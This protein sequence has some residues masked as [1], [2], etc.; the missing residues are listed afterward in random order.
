VNKNRT[1]KIT[2]DLA[3]NST[4]KA[5]NNIIDKRFSS[6]SEFIPFAKEEMKKEIPDEVIADNIK[7]VK[8]DPDLS[9][10]DFESVLGDIVHEILNWIAFWALVSKFQRQDVTEAWKDMIKK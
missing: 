8:N 9:R 10:N 4:R 2:G 7:K 1:I 3:A 5:I 6:I